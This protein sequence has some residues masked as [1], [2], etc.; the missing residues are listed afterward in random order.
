MTDSEPV[1]GG[2]GEKNRG[3]GV[4]K[5]LKPCVYKHTKHVKVRC[6]TFCR[7]VRRVYV[8]SEVKDFRSGAAGKPSVKSARVACIRPETG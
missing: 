4:K 3:S 7:M 8:R 6:G 1:P 5:N 2:K